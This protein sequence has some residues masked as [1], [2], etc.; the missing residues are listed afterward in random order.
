MA[1][2]DEFMP[3]DQVT[4]VPF[5]RADGTVCAKNG[6]DAASRAVL[7]TG[8]SGM[9]RLDIPV[10]PSAG[11]AAAAAR[12]LL[13]EWLGDF[14]WQDEASRASALALVLTPFIRGL[15]PLVPLAV[16]S[17][18]QPGVG[19]GLLADCIQ[20]MITGEAAPPLPWL[21]PKDDDENRKQITAAF[22]GGSSLMWFDEAHQIESPNLSRAITSLTYADRILGVSVQASFPNR[23][24]WLASGNNV[25][26]NT[27]MARRVHWIKLHPDMP[28]PENRPEEDFD[29]P[30]LRDWT[31]ASRPELV[32][33]ALVV[34]RAWYA[35]GKPA[36]NRGARMGSFERWDEIMSGVLA[37]AGVPGFLG[38]LAETRAERDTSSGYWNE[39]LAW[40]HSEF[41]YAEFTV[42]Q[43]ISRA[44]ASSGTWDAPPGLDDLQQRGYARNL[45]AAYGK[46]KDRWFGQL[47]L[48]KTGTGHRTVAKWAVQE[49]TRDPGEETVTDLG[50]MD[51]GG[52]SL[53][54]PAHT[55]S[56]PANTG[57]HEEGT[58]AD[59][60]V[61]GP[62]NGIP[63]LTCEG[64]MEGSGGISTPQVHGRAGAHDARAHTHT[65]GGG[66]IPPDPSIPPTPGLSFGFDLE[67]ADAKK[68]FTYRSH[69]DRGFIRLA[70]VIGSVPVITDAPSLLPLLDSA[71][72]VAGHNILGFDGLALAWHHRRD[73]PGWWE[74]FAA[75]ALD[76]E[77]IARQVWPPKSK[78]THSEDKLGLDNVA[79]LLG[80]PGKTDD[81]KRLKV[82]HKGY[83][84]IPLDD[85]EYLSYLD[86]DLRA[87]AA[88][89]ARLREYY[90]ADSYLPREHQVA[91][92]NGRMSL[93]GFRVDQ[94]LLRQRLEEGAGRKAAALQALHHGWGLPLGRTV[95]RGRGKAKHDV[96]EEGVSPLGTDYG[97]AWLEGQWERYQVPDPPRTQKTGKLS[98]KAEELRKIAGNPVCPADLR[99]M[100][101][102][103]A[104]VTTTRT[105]YQTTQ[106]CL[107]DDGRVHPFVSMRQASGRS[108]VTE[109]GLTVF[110]KHGGRHVERDILIPDEGFVLMSFDLSQVDMRAIAGHCQDPA[111]MALFEP[112]R[113]AHAEIAVRVFGDPH[114]GHCPKGCQMRQDAKSRG[115]GWNY[116]MGPD[117]M[118]RDGVDPKVAYGF[119]NGMKQEFP[120]LCAKRDEWR[121]TAEAGGILDN[122]FGRRMRADPAE[123]YTVAPALMGQ[124]TAADIMKQWILNCP[125]EL[126]Q[127][128]MVT[129]HDEQVFQFPEADWQDMS[130]AVVQASEG[131]FM[132]VPI[133]CDQS[134]PGRSWGEISTK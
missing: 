60:A 55:G 90:D 35:A 8:N 31:A 80:L 130:R 84:K 4:T 65:R 68:L 19:K 56:A 104:V 115:H 74:S 106:S 88:V 24:T 109:P 29:H 26:V 49:I 16:I 81:L 10:E 123:A 71:S 100:L 38:N 120:V 119:D 43:V 42:L 33:A 126:D 101:E 37:Y 79:E 66:E 124:G 15:V 117:R 11:D 2:A 89:S 86:G 129:V 112:G 94:D 20:I 32:T 133:L 54:V 102:M 70:G 69:D 17:G 44:Q 83:D 87:T 53:P 52:I 97:R 18:L 98:V 22:R 75:K 116:G 103:M 121:A 92:I 96:F 47:K 82:Q 39:H 131:D 114:G 73:D 12:Y 51:T 95:S 62:V 30:H 72:E 91:A 36:C 28:D 40:L 78:E 6:Y 3:L 77:L 67:T 5:I 34:I 111:Y 64:G 46:N 27:D 93:N 132:G 50:G 63:F 76:T 118:I 45:G 134:G 107:C 1:S 25:D 13:D 41:G 57:L 21:P 99:A 113:D 14:C 108:S 105:I 59:Q 122:G 58:V 85:P 110:G 7:V 128:R 48:V 23:V 127:Y 125:R 61:C 9:D